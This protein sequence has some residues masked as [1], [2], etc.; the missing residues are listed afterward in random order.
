MKTEIETEMTT[1]YAEDEDKNYQSDGGD[2]DMGTFETE[3]PDNGESITLVI[4]SW[5]LL[6]FEW[7]LPFLLI[8]AEHEDK[9]DDDLDKPKMA[10]PAELGM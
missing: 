2:G 4:V 9:N 8:S 5:S 1:E 6:T 3:S 7:F 10:T